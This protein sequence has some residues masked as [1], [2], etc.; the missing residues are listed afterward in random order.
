MRFPENLTGF[1]SLGFGT[2]AAGLSLMTPG[3]LFAQSADQSDVAALK[4]QM[5]RMQ[6][7]YEERISSMES[8]MK[9][10]ESKAD[11]GSILNTRVLTDSNGTA[12]AG[13]DEKGGPLLDE[14]FLKSLTRYFT[15][16][17]YIRSGVGFNGN[18][19]PQDFSFRIPESGPTLGGSR[20]R[21][22]NENDTYMELTWKQTHMLG[23]GADTPNVS[24]TFTPA[25][26]YN[27]DK[28]TFID[29]RN[30]GSQWA[31]RQAFVEMTNFIKTAPEITIWGGQRFY[32]RH[33][34]HLHD[35]FFDDYSGYGLGIQNIPLGFAKLDVAYLGGIRDDLST[36]TAFDASHGGFYLHTF[37]VRL[38][39]IDLGPGK[40]ELLGDLQFLRSGRYQLATD[41][42]LN[43]ALNVGDTYGYRVGGIYTVPFGNKSFWQISAIYG[44][45]ASANFST[46]IPDAELTAAYN[47]NKN[48]GRVNTD[49]TIGTNSL[50]RADRFRA[51]GQVVWNVNDSFSF[52]ADVHYIYD[53]Q[54]AL[55]FGGFTLGG[56]PILNSGSTQVLGGGIRPVF[57]INDWFAIQG[58]AGVEYVDN[59]R[60]NSE[61]D[62][63][64]NQVGAFGRSGEMGIFT[65]APTIRPR[66]GFFSR[67]EFRVFGTYAI[68]SSS[69]KGTFG[70]V[71]PIT[72][73]QTYAGSNQGWVFGVQTEWFF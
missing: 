58:Q 36:G 66:G 30:A 43:G 13:K 46:D 56:A 44:A 26:V 72:G 47:L 33:D 8:Q 41:S 24:M 54:G 48:L 67:P 53:N 5:D 38:Q 62:A 23:D 14:S 29:Q 9:Q 18:G 35:Y 31:M 4:A 65:I 37:D 40:L 64:G 68:W 16:T 6:K 55:S 22:G 10:L 50:R 3:A 61:L 27:T 69:L 45:G 17:A 21:L 70:G 49:G 52:Q 25:V 1:R 39:D 28:A 71:S 73:T 7:Q 57:Q 42:G 2:L 34:V 59:V 20:Y 51:T 32:D 11:S 19:G 15:F 63:A 12:W 60:T